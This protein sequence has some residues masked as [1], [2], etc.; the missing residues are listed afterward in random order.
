MNSKQEA[1]Q[2]LEA[3]IKDFKLTRTEVGIAI[4]KNK[5]FMDWMENP[6]KSI[7]TRTLDTIH[8]YVLEVRGQGKLDLEN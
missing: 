3:L 1:L 7:T 5:S 8:R 4:T 6:K 2:E